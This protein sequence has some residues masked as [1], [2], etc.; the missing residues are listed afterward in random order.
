MVGNSSMLFATFVRYYV[1]YSHPMVGNILKHLRIQSP[2]QKMW[3]ITLHWAQLQS[4]FHI[5]LLQ[6]PTVRLRIAFA[7][8]AQILTHGTNQWVSTHITTKSVAHR[9]LWCK[10]V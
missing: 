9:A 5:P 3:L 6:D 7:P 10:R 8:Y 1:C 2:F 4:G